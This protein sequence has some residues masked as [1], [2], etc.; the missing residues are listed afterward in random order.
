[1]L[2]RIA[3][4]LST[5][6]DENLLNRGIVQYFFMG[7]EHAVLTRPHGNSKKS[8][9]YIRTMPSTL[10][11][12]TDIA[13][14]LTPKP[15]VHVVSS[16]A[17]GIIGATSAGS[18]P[19]NTRQVKD[20]R[21]KMNT[22]SKDPL[23]SVMMMC[24]ES[25]KDF[26]RAVTGAPD[27]MVVLSFD[28]TL[29]NLVRF[30]ANPKLPSI[31][32][33]DPTFNLGPFDVT[34]TTYKH[35]LLVYR[36][37][38]EHT[39][40]HPSLIGPVLIHQRKQFNNYHYFTAAIVGFRQNLC[41]LTAFGTDGEVALVQAC[42]SQ[43]PSAVHLRCWLHFKDN[44]KNKLERDLRL[45]S[46]LAQEFIADVLGNA[47]SLERGLVEAADDETFDTQLTS[48][49]EVW[50]EREQQF[51]KSDP[52]FYDW[53]KKNSSEVVK[54]TMLWSVRQS[55][56]LGL[57]PSP[58]YTNAVE[59]INGLLKLRANYKKQDLVTFITKL[60]E[61]L[62]SQFAEVD[63]AL[64]GFGDY[65]VAEE[66]QQFQYN[67]ASW[68]AMSESQRKRIQ[69]QFMS[70]KPVGI[71]DDSEGEFEME[72]QSSTNPLT[73]L[74]V[75]DYVADVIWKSANDLL[76]ADNSIVR[77]PGYATQSWVVARS[78][79]SRAKPY[80]VSI[81]KGHYECES[82][83]IY[84]HTS[85]V[86][87]H[88]VAV[89][90]TNGDLEKFVGWHKKRQHGVNVTNLAESGLP[91]SCIGKK[92]STRKGVSKKKSAKIS[93]VIARASESSWKP[94]AAL[95]TVCSSTVTPQPIISHST[96]SSEFQHGHTTSMSSSSSLDPTTMGSLSTSSSFHQA[97]AA[98]SSSFRCLPTL[99]ATPSP[100][101][102][103]FYRQQMNPFMITFIQGN[104][105]VCFGC[106]QYYRKPVNPPDD[107]CIVHR[108]WRTFTLAGSPVPQSRFGNAYYHL[109][110]MCVR[111]VWP[112]FDPK[113]DLLVPNDVIA[114]LLQCHKDVL[115][116]F[117]F[118]F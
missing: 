94:R 103:N 106:K 35:P 20:V 51:T 58:Y 24:K 110:S 3:Q 2:L 57:P 56:G 16:Q 41:S 4:Y 60:K 93:K 54:K 89:A 100:T 77:A 69:M 80:F 15:A 108:E 33:F 22:R 49:K 50:N 95:K 34:V 47:S 115:R 27:Y 104:I 29:D 8:Y 102:G 13:S 42:H 37:P 101:A 38:K 43:F 111:S 45:P 75:T 17:G 68:C 31:L 44:L 39:S 81:Q 82:D 52:V 92:T 9:P 46:E 25:M 62:E 76:Q 36:N 6:Y 88:I 14:E 91:K 117:G 86:C 114:A 84:Y 7:E 61:L 87:A 112:Q 98:P 85:K 63:R 67:S 99:P 55:A 118:N 74:D 96:S 107:L 48:L 113:R 70:A 90:K 40:M 28:R 65:K 53:F 26:V 19:R 73:C 79:S 109:H 1:M 10:E 78:S 116:I 32:T 72:E 30:C 5:D 23:H 59:S 97:T 83:C 21:R 66:Y 71:K 18:L 11:K 64:A 105:S 12:L